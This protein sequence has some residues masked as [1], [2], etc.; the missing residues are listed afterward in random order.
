M[1]PTVAEVEHISFSLRKT[2]LSLPHELAEED[3]LFLEHAGAI[4]QVDDW[5]AK[6]EGVMSKAC[7]AKF[8]HNKELRDA[9]LRTEDAILLHNSPDEFWGLGDGTG[10]NKLGEMLMSIREELKRQRDVIARPPSPQS[11]PKRKDGRFLF[12]S[13]FAH[14]AKPFSFL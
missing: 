6:H 10:R 14:I 2:R 7:H 13:C 8:T 1:A 9:L 12:I 11:S 3:A 4:A 5:T